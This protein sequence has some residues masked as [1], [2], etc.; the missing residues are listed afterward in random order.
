MIQSDLYVQRSRSA[1]GYKKLVLILFLFCLCNLEVRAEKDT[2]KVAKRL[3]RVASYLGGSV[4]LTNSF[5]YYDLESTVSQLTE[6]S[7]QTLRIGGCFT[8]DVN[9]KWAYYISVGAEVNSRHYDFDYENKWSSRTGQYLVNV[10]TSSFRTEHVG[11]RLVHTGAYSIENGVIKQAK[12]YAAFQA[13]VNLILNQH[14]N[15]IT[16]STH[17]I[18]SSAHGEKDLFHVNIA[19]GMH[20]EHLNGNFFVF[21]RYMLG[22]DPRSLD[23]DVVPSIYGGKLSTNSVT[24]GFRFGVGMLLQ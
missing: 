16:A 18:G 17:I 22:L 6:F 20:W 24:L 15:G 1:K 8:I 4:N 10:R 19:A 2:A 3:P 14:Y 13:G 9:D 21:H 5:N 23:L 11:L 7:N 12:M